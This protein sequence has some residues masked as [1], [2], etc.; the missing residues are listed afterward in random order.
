MNILL[1][2]NLSWRLVKQLSPYFSRALHISQT[3]LANPATDIAIWNWAKLNQFIIVTND[4]DFRD[5]LSTYGFPPKVVLLR[6]GNLSTDDIC[7][8]L[9]GCKTEIDLLHQSDTYGLIEIY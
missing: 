9:I 3:N 1:D 7:R 4:D 5:L 8:V 2:A 6:K